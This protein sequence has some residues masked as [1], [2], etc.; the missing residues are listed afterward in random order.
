MSQSPGEEGGLPQ[1]VP[2]INLD[3]PTQTVAT[4]DTPE[5]QVSPVVDEA[6]P[7]S[8]FSFEMLD[9]ESVPAPYQEVQPHWF[10]C[11]RSD[12]NT[13]WLPFSRE[14]SDK[15]ENACNTVKDQEDEVVIAVEGERYDVHVKER[16][17]YAV[18][19]EQGPTEVRRCTW[20]YKGDKDTIF[21][22]YPEDVSK[23][24][25]EAYM[26]AVTLNEWKR[27]LEFSNGETVIL[28]NPKLIMQYQPIGLQD[29]WVSSPSEQTRPQTV[30]RG[31]NNI[32]VEIPDGMC[33]CVCMCMCVCV[34][35]CVPVRNI[36][37]YK[38][39]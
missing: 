17:R 9:M 5:E 19:W 36:L 4:G 34:C 21:L 26:I 32:S 29:D 3:N 22:P 16:K 27:K 1:A 23:S 2:N 14:D 8:T 10:F 35:V 24:L 20:F 11:R 15:L 12:D 39:I 38:L 37:E 25:E 30:K 6:S 7:S 18:Y 13:S 28:H 31:V 33:V